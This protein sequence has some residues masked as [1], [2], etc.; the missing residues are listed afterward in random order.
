MKSKNSVYSVSSCSRIRVITMKNDWKTIFPFESKM[1][2]S[3]RRKL[4][5]YI[6]LKSYR[7]N[8]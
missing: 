2:T 1:S 7:R 3:G 8:S 6:V 5:T 4:S